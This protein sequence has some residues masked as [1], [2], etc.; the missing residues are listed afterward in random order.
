MPAIVDPALPVVVAT[1]RPLEIFHAP[2]GDRT[3]CGLLT[4][5]WYPMPAGAAYSNVCSPCRMCF[6]EPLDRSTGS[7]PGWPIG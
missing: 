3:A 4:I 7:G 2:I 6:P 1:T 5:G